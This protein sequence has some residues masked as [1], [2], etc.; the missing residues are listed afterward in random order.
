MSDS[1]SDRLWH[2]YR[3]PWP[4]KAWQTGQGNLPWHDPDFADRMLRQHLD[5]SHGAASRQTTERAW[6][7]DWFWQKMGLQAGHH[8]L[9]V[10][11]GP[12]LYAV[13]FAKRG[14]QVTGIDISPTAVA[15]AAELAQAYQVS[16]RCAFVQQDMRQMQLP[17]ATYDGAILLYGQL[18]VMP[19]DEAQ[20]VLQQIAAALKPGAKLCL[21]LLNQDRV[22]KTDSSWWF[23]DDSGL[24]GGAPFLH[25]GERFWLADE[26][27][28]VERYHIL[29]LKTGQM[30]QIELCDQTYA[31]AEV[32]AMLT[33]AGFATTAVYPAW[34]N[35]PLYDA[36]EWNVYLASKPPLGA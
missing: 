27:I 6:Q 28:S 1:L 10:T 32:E 17:A 18:A 7:I 34:E 30:D 25:L 14:C 23:T 2:I 35:G 21:E 12:G 26:Q 20:A 19:K 31:V 36:A 15:Y 22:D 16:Q 9:D 13:E 29:H 8:L 24:W 11:C 4:P 3:R 33:E 5:D